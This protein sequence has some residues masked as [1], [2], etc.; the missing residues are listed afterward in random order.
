MAITLTQD[1]RNQTIVTAT[2]KAAG[3]KVSV[4]M[5]LILAILD[6]NPGTTIV[7][8]FKDFTISEGYNSVISSLQWNRALT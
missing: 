1:S 5:N 7:T 3:I 8:S 2:D 4:R 6:A